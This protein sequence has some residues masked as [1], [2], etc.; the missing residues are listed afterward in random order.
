MFLKKDSES[1]F[2]SNSLNKSEVLGKE[3]NQFQE[4][5]QQNDI[6]E[7]DLERPRLVGEGGYGKVFRVFIRNSRK[8]F[9]NENNSDLKPD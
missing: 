8:F 2:H 5:I 4:N 1:S 9:K 6:Q 7:S 3:I